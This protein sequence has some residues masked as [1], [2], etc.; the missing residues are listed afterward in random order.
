[1][2][3]LDETSYQIKRLNI[4]I[5]QELV[6]DNIHVQRIE[7]IMKSQQNFPE[8]VFEPDIDKEQNQDVDL[9]Q[10]QGIQEAITPSL[11]AKKVSLLNYKPFI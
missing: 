7:N 5:K 1:M 8:F 9:M 11:K 2:E 3:G 6:D 10:P 4:D